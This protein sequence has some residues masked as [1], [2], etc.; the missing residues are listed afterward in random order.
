MTKQFVQIVADVHCTWEGL[1]P[2]Y[3]L[4][5]NDELFTERTWD[6]DDKYLEELVSIEA[7]PG[8]YRLRW[9]LVAPH[10]AHMDIVN[11]RAKAGR[12]LIFPDNIVRIFD[13][14]E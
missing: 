13:E 1:K 14:A 2:I 9:E 5:V 3:R 6:W 7:E 10:L 11:L 12:I 4:Y 8:D